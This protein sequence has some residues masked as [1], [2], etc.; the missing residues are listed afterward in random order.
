M[1]LEGARERLPCA[2]LTLGILEARFPGSAAGWSTGS[3]DSPAAEVER[4]SGNN[5]RPCVRRCL[6]VRPRTIYA[7]EGTP[8]AKE[9]LR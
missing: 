6:R 8:R 4:E 1:T 5:G 9:G 3:P 7:G 2:K